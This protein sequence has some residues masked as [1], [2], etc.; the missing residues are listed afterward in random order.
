MA[1]THA[2]RADDRAGSANGQHADHRAEILH[3][4]VWHEENDDTFVN[5]LIHSMQQDN[6]CLLLQHPAWQQRFAHIKRH[7]PTLYKGKL[8]R[9][10]L[11]YLGT[12]QGLQWDRE[13]DVFVYE[14]D[15]LLTVPLSSIEP[16]DVE[17]LWS[18]YVPYKKLTLVEGD[19]EGGKT[20][21]LLAIAAA[22][23]RGYALPDQDGH[24][25][26]PHH[27]CGNVLYIT[28]E[29]GLADTI[30]KRAERC[31]ADLDRIFVVPH[32][33]MFPGDM[34]PFSLARPHLLSAAI[35]EREARLVILDPLTAF[36]G[37]DIDMHRAN[38]VRPLMSRLVAMAE[39]HH[40]AIMAIRHWTKLAGGRAA[41]RGQGNIDFL[42]AARSVL[43]VGRSPEDEDLRIMA[44]SKNSIEERGVSIVFQISDRGLEWAGTSL[45]TA[46]ELSA[47]QPHLHK[48][49]RQNAMEWLRDY[50]REGAQPST[51]VVEASK[52][53]GI[54]EKALR[55]AKEALGVLAAKEGNTWFWRL[56]KF[57]KWDRY[58]GM[59][60]D[61]DVAL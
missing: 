36:M 3:A 18:P 34:Q 22:V 46:D 13:I 16:E 2:Q 41:Y 1:D 54:N 61:D 57:S 39:H 32:A 12:Q 23:T 30:R 14:Y 51:A 11:M 7:N 9:A 55:R 17:W 50:L 28:A 53:V 38:E 15:R 37:S 60:D 20:Y 6:Y 47:S 40:C 19:P 4:L 33:S 45:M 27:T 44:Q 10:V 25:A 8:L 35:E 31:N 56:P 48:K 24:I 26:S 29:D 49:Q 59:E 52:A 43:A 21:L 42:A 58:A 5:A